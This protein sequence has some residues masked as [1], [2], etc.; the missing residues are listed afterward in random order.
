[1]FSGEFVRFCSSPHFLPPLTWVSFCQSAAG[2]LA[3]RHRVHRASGRRGQYR[4]QTFALQSF[5]FRD[6]DP[7]EVRQSR[8]DV[9][10]LDAGVGHNNVQP[11]RVGENAG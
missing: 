3:E 1:M 8:E 2:E 5:G 10:G 4:D 9:D 7:S 11:Q 6:R